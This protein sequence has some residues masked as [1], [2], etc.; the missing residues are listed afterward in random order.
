MFAD[1]AYAAIFNQL[2][3]LGPDA[4]VDAI[5]DALDEDTTQVLQELMNESGGLDRA[6]ETI[7]G[8]INSLLSREISNRMNDID[9]LLPLA[10][11]DQIDDLIREKSKLAIEMQALGRPRWKSFNS[12]RS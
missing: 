8:S 5:A 11:A 6:N 4:G 9:R 2:V 12:S 7:D 10:P 1:S 3:I